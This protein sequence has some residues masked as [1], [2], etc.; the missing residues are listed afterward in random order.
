MLEAGIKVAKRTIETYRR[1]N[2]GADPDSDKV[3]NFYIE[4]D[5]FYELKYDSEKKEWRLTE[6]RKTEEV[7]IDDKT[8]SN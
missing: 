5:H 4:F 7:L 8:E 2:K 1:K 3:S 6:F